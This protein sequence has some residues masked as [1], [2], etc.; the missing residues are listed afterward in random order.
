M[1]PVVREVHGGFKRFGA[2]IIAAGFALGSLEH[3]VGLVLLAFHIEMY[4]AYPAWRHA[5][6]AMVD[7]SIAYL[8]IRHSDRLFIPLFAFLIEQIATNGVAAYQDWEATHHASWV[9]VVM[10]LLI[11]CATAAAGANRRATPEPAE[12][13]ELLE[14]S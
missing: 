6:F 8:A 1:V 2:P 13:L 14:P 3:A 10:H 4:A 9:V 11:A 12:P 7:A 5:A